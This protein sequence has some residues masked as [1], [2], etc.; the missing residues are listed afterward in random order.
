MMDLQILEELRADDVVAHATYNIGPSGKQSI[1]E[2][3]EQISSI[4]RELDM[5]RERFNRMKRRELAAKL[6]RVA[7]QLS[8]VG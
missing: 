1:I 7:H 4:Y 5:L 2:I 6:R 3:Q 8:K